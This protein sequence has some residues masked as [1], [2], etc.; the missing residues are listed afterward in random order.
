MCLCVY[1]FYVFGEGKAGAASSTPACAPALVISRDKIVLGTACLVANALQLS[2]LS[3]WQLYYFDEGKYPHEC[4]FTK[5]L[6]AGLFGCTSSFVGCVL[7]LLQLHHSRTCITW[8]PP[9]TEAQ[10]RAHGAV[11]RGH[12]SFRHFSFRCSK[13]ARIREASS[14]VCFQEIGGQVIAHQ[15]L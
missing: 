13:S 7:V 15:F 5:A 8:V 11:L 10:P 1:C 12:E 3:M 2:R 14:S 9:D 4:L 6:L